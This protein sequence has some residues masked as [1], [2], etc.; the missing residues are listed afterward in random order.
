MIDNQYY[1]FKVYLTN[2]VDNLVLAFLEGIGNQ[3]I[4]G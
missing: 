1:F 2:N 4:L 3:A